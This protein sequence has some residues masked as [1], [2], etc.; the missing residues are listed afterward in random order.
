[1]IP[2]ITKKATTQTIATV[3]SC[4]GFGRVMPIAS[5]I[6]FVNETSNRISM[7]SEPR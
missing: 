1:M 2:I 7:G 5:M 3:F 4:S 6:P